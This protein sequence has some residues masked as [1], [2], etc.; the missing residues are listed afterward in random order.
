MRSAASAAALMMGSTPVAGPAAATAA[1]CPL[2]AQAYVQLL[3]VLEQD[4]A[5]AL[6]LGSAI[7]G[8]LVRR[9]IYF[10][11]WRCGAKKMV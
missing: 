9:C 8:R 2:P 11:L 7:C 6:G 1:A 3:Y 4:V 5:C 10:G